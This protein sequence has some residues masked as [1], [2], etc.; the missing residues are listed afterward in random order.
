MFVALI[1]RVVLDVKVAK[2]FDHRVWD[3]AEKAAEYYAHLFGGRR[4]VKWTILQVGTPV[5]ESSTRD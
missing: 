3:D 2:T 4:D 5:F 1:D